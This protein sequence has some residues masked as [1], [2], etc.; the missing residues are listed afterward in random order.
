[1]TIRVCQYSCLIVALL[2][3]SPK[4]FSMV[5]LPVN[6]GIGAQTLQGPAFAPNANLTH[7][8]LEERSPTSLSPI[9]VKAQVIAKLKDLQKSQNE[10]LQGLEQNLKK[11]LQ[12]SQNISLKV[13][14]SSVIDRQFVQLTTAIENMQ[15]KRSEFLLRRDFIDQLIFRLDSK[16]TSQPLQKFLEQEFLEM[17]INELETPSDAK[18]WK[19]L[20]YMSIAVREIPEA[21][22]N[23]IGFIDGYLAFSSIQNPKSPNDYLQKRNYTNGSMSVTAR[24]ANAEQAGDYVAAKM[25]EL[26]RLH[27][28]NGKDDANE[29][30]IQLKMRLTPENTEPQS[31]SATRSGTTRENPK[32]HQSESN[33]NSERQ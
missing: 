10:T 17:A 28:A 19:F 21:H 11:Q 7:T 3:S 12:E 1:M 8:A 27:K 22:E 23:L 32:V 18:M 26:H 6:L 14:D 29:A 16:W 20:T 4:G 33:T 5:T 30:D 13:A 25:D 2:L 15:R 31:N 24:P 9:A